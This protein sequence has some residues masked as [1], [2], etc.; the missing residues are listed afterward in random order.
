MYP[1][2]DASVSGGPTNRQGI[3]QLA[4]NGDRRPVI[5]CEYAHSMGNSTGNLKEYW[6]AVH[7]Y[8]RLQGGFIWDWVDQGLR[9]RA[10]NGEEFWAY[11]G[12]FGDEINDYNFCINGLIWPDRT[13][14]PAMWECKKIFQPAWIEARNWKAGK[15]RVFNKRHFASLDD[16]EMEWELAADGEVLQCGRETDL[17]IPAGGAK[18]Y[19]LPLRKPRLKPGAECFLNVRLV[20]KKDTLWAKAGHIVAWEQLPAPYKAPKASILPLDDMMALEIEESAGSLALRGRAFEM[21]FDKERGAI[22]SWSRRGQALITEGPRVNIWRAP[23]DNDGMPWHRR[24]KHMLLGRWFDAGLDRLQT[25][26]VSVSLSQVDERWACIETQMRL[27]APGVAA[28]FDCSLGYIVYEN[29]E[30]KIDAKI[31][32]FGDLPPLPRLGLTMRLPLE[33]DRFAWLGRGPQESYWDRKAGVAVGLHAGSV[34]EQYV[35]YIMP[36][37]NGNKTDVRWAALIDPKGHGLMAIGKKPF[38]TSVHRYTAEDLTRAQH[39]HELRKRDFVVWNLDWRQCGL[40]GASCGPGTLPQYLIQPAK[41]RF[42]IVLRPFGA[43][44][45]LDEIGRY[46]IK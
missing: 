28:G 37:E 2:V 46:K 36:Q 44:L 38:E 14:H 24:V 29:G 39:T 22:A 43:G 8:K 4:Q 1:Q 19:A 10:A 40:G 32:P 9:M 42:R 3:V 21:R 18:T 7:A 35:P 45:P 33:Y 20:L 23:T 11:G 16:L 41:V 27:Q 5:M 13:P 12:D 15:I 25:E 26:V 6:E 17:D 30:T 34:D 31:A